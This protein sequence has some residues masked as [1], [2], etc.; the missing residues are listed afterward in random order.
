MHSE[1][2]H[3]VENEYCTLRST[4][5]RMNEAYQTGSLT[6]SSCAND[7]RNACFI[8][9]EQY[10]KN[11]SFNCAGSKICSMIRCELVGNQ[12]MEV[13]SNECLPFPCGCESFTKTWNQ[14]LP[15]KICS[16]LD[17]LLLNLDSILMHSAQAQGFKC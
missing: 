4:A 12:L 7:I 3:E 9:K 14:S 11:K 6:W 1:V 10:V 16:S 15:Q 13:E 17:I 2:N 8:F 5:E